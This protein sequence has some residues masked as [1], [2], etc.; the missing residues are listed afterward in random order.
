[1]QAEELDILSS[2]TP[3]DLWNEDLDVFDTA[4]AE[5][6]EAEAKAAKKVP[7][8]PPHALSLAVK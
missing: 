1:M 2:K 8:P 5:F 7:R 3:A 4:Y 6:E